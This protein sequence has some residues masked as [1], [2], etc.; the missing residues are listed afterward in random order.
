MIEKIGSFINGDGFDSNEIDTINFDIEQTSKYNQQK[1]SGT[2]K[3]NKQGFELEAQN[4]PKIIQKSKISLK[5]AKA[6][7]NEQ[8]NIFIPVQFSQ[9]NQTNISFEQGIKSSH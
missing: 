3:L 9:K 5:P 2:Q 7:A 8:S 4:N 1:F 6:N